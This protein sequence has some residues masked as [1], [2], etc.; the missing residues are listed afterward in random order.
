M[1]DL[2]KNK[3]YMVLA[4]LHR[5]KNYVGVDRSDTNN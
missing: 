2:N 1:G 3:L 4:N 5:G